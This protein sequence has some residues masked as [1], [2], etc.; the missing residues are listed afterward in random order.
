MRAVGDKTPLVP[1]Q[2]V[3]LHVCKHPACCM[4]GCCFSLSLS[5][6]LYI[7]IYIIAHPQA[8]PPRRSNRQDCHY[9]YIYISVC[10]WTKCL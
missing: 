2:C 3:H 4:L 7:Y 1:A 9:I 8:P 10:L 6:S 5:L